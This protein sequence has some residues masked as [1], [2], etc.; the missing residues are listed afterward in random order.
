MD[1]CTYSVR[2]WIFDDNDNIKNVVATEEISQRTLNEMS[3]L[4]GNLLEAM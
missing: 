1:M 2:A 3:A 4:I